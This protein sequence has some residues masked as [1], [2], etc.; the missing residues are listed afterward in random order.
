PGLK[1]LLTSYMP[2]FQTVIVDDS[3]FVYFYLYGAGVGE[4]PDLAL[5]PADPGEP[6]RQRLIWST[7]RQMLAPETVPYIQHGRVH[8]YWE[9]TK[10][11]SW[12]T[13]TPEER[14]AHRITHEFY[15][16]HAA[17]VHERVGFALEEEVKA[18]LDLLRGRTLVLGCGSGKEVHHL[19][20]RRPADQVLGV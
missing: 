9:R 11:A 2:P 1:V 13:W 17:Q 18:H 4:M 20:S 14:K 15:A 3:V 10:L 6:L 19:A 16:T 8:D 7:G 5:M 12:D